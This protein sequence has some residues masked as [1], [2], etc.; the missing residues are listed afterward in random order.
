MP[1]GW[2]SSAATCQIGIVA[3]ATVQYQNL[4]PSHYTLGSVWLTT[5]PT[6]LQDFSAVAAVDGD[7]PANAKRSL[8]CPLD[9][10]TSKF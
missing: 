4:A 7:R 3:A 10:R 5:R 9:C 8:F 2:L 6:D 1:V